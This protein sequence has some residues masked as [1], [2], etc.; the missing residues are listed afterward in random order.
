MMKM[1]LVS[2]VIPVYNGSNFLAEAIRSALGQTYENIEVIVV[3]DGSTDGGK[4]EAVAKSFGE[5]IRY[6]SKPN[7]GVSSALNLGIQNMQ[8]EYFCWLSHDDLYNPFKIEKQIDF[9]RS[10]QDARIVASYF[11]IFDSSGTR[12]LFTVAPDIV[13]TGK[14]LLSTWIYFSSML[15]HKSSFDAA[16]TFD[17][18]DRTTQD[19][20]LQ[21]RLLSH[22]PI[23]IIHEVLTYFRRHEEQVT[24]QRPVQHLADKNRL[25]K[26]M[27]RQHGI[28]FFADDP[29]E[30]C[31]Q[32]YDAYRWVGDYALNNGLYKGSEY[33]YFQALKSRPMSPLLCL[34]LIIGF[35]NWFKIKT[36]IHK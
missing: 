6:F 2:I 18:T 3:N 16:G 29:I 36:H 23:Y 33:A 26:K 24:L 32:R 9:F 8:G 17:E 35:E 22:I 11:E 28:D 19:L 12:I 5:S 15:I 20:D 27:L 10:H 21:L 4:T 14:Q 13:K 25:I 31:R 1:P 7:G 30:N 34:Q